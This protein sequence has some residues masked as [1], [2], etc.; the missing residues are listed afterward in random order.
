MRALFPSRTMALHRAMNVANLPHSCRVEVPGPRVPDGEGGTTATWAE[1]T[2][3]PCRVS[4]VGTP[5]ERLAEG[6][7]REGAR[8]VVVFAAR[9]SIPLNARLTVDMDGET[10]VLNPHGHN[11]PRSFEAQ[12]KYECSLWGG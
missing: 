2:T 3:L 8:Y 4:P 11:G 10:L 7:I 9:V 5:V 6:Q 12:R 1:T